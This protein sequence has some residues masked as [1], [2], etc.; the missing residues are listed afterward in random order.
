MGSIFSH[1]TCPHVALFPFTFSYFSTDRYNIRTYSNGIQSMWAE[2]PFY[3]NILFFAPSPSFPLLF[4]GKSFHSTWLRS[5]WNKYYN[6]MVNNN[7]GTE[8]TNSECL[9]G[10]KGY[11]FSII[12]NSMNFKFP[13]LYTV[14]F[15]CPFSHM[16]LTLF[17]RQISWGPGQDENIISMSNSLHTRYIIP[18]SLNL[19][20]ICL[21]NWLHHI[22]LF[23][24][25]QFTSV[26]CHMM[27]IITNLIITICMEWKKKLYSLS[28]C[29]IELFLSRYLSSVS[30]ALYIALIYIFALPI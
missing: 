4:V 7:R 16:L 6:V 9:K 13:C 5:W 8:N 26:P 22:V 27:K 14:F 20:I 24:H 2:F 30:N 15:P 23:T 1:S 3:P 29:V 10:G 12:F 19:I 11:F 17:S 28:W 18:F 25:F 21:T